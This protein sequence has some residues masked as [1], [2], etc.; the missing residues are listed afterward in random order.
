MYKY[1]IYLFQSLFLQTA[2]ATVQHFGN[3][4]SASSLMFQSLF[5]QTAFAT[6]DNTQSILAKY[7]NPC[8]RRRLLQPGIRWS[9]RKFYSSFNPCF[10]RR[11]LQ[12]RKILFLFTFKV[13]TLEYLKLS[14]FFGSLI[15][16]SPGFIKSSS[17]RIIFKSN[18]ILKR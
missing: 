10:R 16:R 3:T 1:R 5:W 2:F 15:S 7:F 9:Y 14:I 6:T 13:C 4:Y 11:L 8:F 17:A 18:H 12:P